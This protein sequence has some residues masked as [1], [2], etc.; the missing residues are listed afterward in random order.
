M[1]GV[2][3]K[4]FCEFRYDTSHQSPHDLLHLGRQERGASSVK[5]PSM[6]C[7]GLFLD[8]ASVLQLEVKELLQGVGTLAVLAVRVV[9][10][11]TVGDDP[12]QVSNEKL[13]GHVVSVLQSLCHGL[14]VCGST[15][16]RDCLVSMKHKR[17][18]N[19]VRCL[20]DR[21]ESE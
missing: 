2:A 14:Q 20:T 3:Y 11:A 8:Q 16:E 13:L 15:R 5:I 9:V 12:L 17:E 21:W 7:G 1:S 4:P 10:L 18:V 6:I 19:Q